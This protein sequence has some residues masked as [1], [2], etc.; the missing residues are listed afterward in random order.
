MAQ[1]PTEHHTVSDS[2]DCVVG[3]ID[4]VISSRVKKRSEIEFHQ[5]ILMYENVGHVIKRLRNEEIFSQLQ[6]Q[7][8]PVASC[9]KAIH[10]G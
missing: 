7:F 9:D 6:P 3:C 8:Y 4:C 10:L 5:A 1:V 2:Q